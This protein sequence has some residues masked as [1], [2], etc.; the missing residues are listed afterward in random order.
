MWTLFALAGLA[1]AAPLHFVPHTVATGLKG[2]YQ[3]V[4]ADINH[5]GKPDLIAL[6]SGMTDLV[7]YENPS[8]T[9]HVIASGFTGMINCAAY[10][11]DG[12]GIPEIVLASGFRGPGV[13]PEEGNSGVLTLLEHQGDPSGPWKATLLTRLPASHRL[14]WTPIAKKPVL[15]AVPLT[16]AE[17][18]P[19]NF[20]GHVPITLFDPATWASKIMS[21][22]EEGVVHG[23]FVTDW[24]RGGENDILIAGFNGIH[25]YHREANGTWSRH[26]IAA[27]NPAG[28]PHGGSSDVAA[29]HLGNRRFLC[30]IEPWHGEQVAVYTGN[31][32]W[33]RQVIDSTLVDGHTIVTGDFDASGN[34]TIVAGFRGGARSVYLYRAA[35]SRGE[36]WT[37]EVLDDGGMGAAACAVADLNGDSRPDIACI[38]SGTANLKWYEN[39]ERSSK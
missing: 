3:V 34:D 25:R 22:D 17:A 2:G 14:R 20:F 18:R 15:I 39:A 21:L 35:D 4:A 10:D 24:E 8:W 13:P 12:D 23:V 30:A 27:G 5:D 32:H 33:R 31:K 19:P 6:A 29:G 7:W 11:L 1:A 38:G 9:R 28:W 26:A 37:R 36:N 16:A